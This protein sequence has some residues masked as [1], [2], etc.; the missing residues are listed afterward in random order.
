LAS[1]VSRGGD[2]TQK[3]ETSLLDIESL[4][5]EISDAFFADEPPSPRIRKKTAG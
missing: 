4:G 2:P 1:A 5:W 3:D